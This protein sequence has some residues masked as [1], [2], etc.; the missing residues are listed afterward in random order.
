MQSVKQLLPNKDSLHLG[1]FGDTGSG[2]SKL[3]DELHDAS[4]QTD[5]A[6]IYFNFP[7]KQADNY[8]ISGRDFS[9]KTDPGKIKQAVDNGEQIRYNP[10]SDPD[11]AVNQLK[12]IYQMAKKSS[13]EVY[14]FVDEAHMYASK[15]L[16]TVLDDGRGHNVRFILISQSI[17]KFAKFNKYAD[18]VIDTIFSKGEFIMFEPNPRHL[19]YYEYYDIPHQPITKK[20]KGIDYSFVRM[21]GA[22]IVSGPHRINL[23]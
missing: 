18:F 6:S 12:A 1:I 13:R 21:Q 19:D 14:F 23:S 20:T 3:A 7:Q 15:T 10:S 22:D 2:K 17:K 11:Q 9:Y 5:A 4:K 8:S 16:N